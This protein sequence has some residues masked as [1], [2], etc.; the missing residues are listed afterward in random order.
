MKENKNIKPVIL[1]G[2]YDK[3]CVPHEK[4]I[5]MDRKIPKNVREYEIKDDDMFPYVSF[6]KNDFSNKNDYYGWYMLIPENIMPFF[7][8]ENGTSRMD[9]DCV[10]VVDGDNQIKIERD[11]VIYDVYGK[12]NVAKTSD[13]WSLKLLMIKE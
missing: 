13:N 2:M 10:R 1:C 3:T 12:F 6:S 11:G 9:M 7:I 8:L 5:L 4:T